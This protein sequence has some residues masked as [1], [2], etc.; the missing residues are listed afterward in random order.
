M[1]RIKVKA[2]SKNKKIE[3]PSTTTNEKSK[4]N[5]KIY[6]FSPQTIGQKNEYATFASIKEKIIRR[7]QVELSQGYDVKLSLEKGQLM[8]FDSMKPELEIVD[9]EE[10]MAETEGID[11]S[12]YTPDRQPTD[13]E[14]SCLLYTSPSPRDGATSRMP[15]SA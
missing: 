14:R 7:A 4:E 8:D 2:K 15:S 10:I 9:I 11:E 1:A 3:R 12:L 5:G 6:K 13:K